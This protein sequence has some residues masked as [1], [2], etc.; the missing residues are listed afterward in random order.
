MGLRILQ[1]TTKAIQSKAAPARI[2]LANRVETL[3]LPCD[4]ENECTSDVCLCGDNFL[5]HAPRVRG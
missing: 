3:M 2:T 1:K 5:F 4:E